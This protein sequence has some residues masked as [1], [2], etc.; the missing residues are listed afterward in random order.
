MPRIPTL[1]R[2]QIINEVLN[3]KSY[4]EVGRL[5]GFSHTAIRKLFNKYVQTKSITD[6]P[7]SGR[8]SKSSQRERRNLLRICRTNPKWTSRMLQSAWNT[9]KLISLSTVKRILNK[10]KYFG[11]IAARKPLLSRMHKKNR[12]LWCNAYRR[13]TENEWSKI[14][15]S[16]E[17]MIRLYE[18]KREYVWRPKNTRYNNDYTTGTVKHGGKSLM[19]WGTIN[20]DGSRMLVR[21]PPRLNS[22]EYIK[23]LSEHFVPF[24]DSEKIFMQDN[25][26]IHKSKKV[27]QYIGETGINYID[28]WP[29]QSPDLNII[30][31][32]W[33]ILKRN[34]AYRKPKN[35]HELWAVCVEEWNAI[36]TDYIQRLYKSVPRRME[37][38]IKCRGSNLKY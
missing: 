37:M 22:D 1:D 16:D 11:R 19:I 7:K 36:P 34:I 18:R 6:L 2:Q 20:Y 21:C 9:N 5:F 15:F 30:E 26:P 38:V 27:M 23:I 29:A 31:N 32:M 14:I 17:S 8:P 4:R 13:W 24:Y 12:V 35:I 28:D 33:C 25:A 10:A 3:G